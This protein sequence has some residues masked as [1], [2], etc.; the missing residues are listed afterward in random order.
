MKGKTVAITTSIGGSDQN[1]TMRFL[2]RD[3]MDP[4]RDIKYKSTDSGAAVLAMQNGEIAAALLSDQFIQKFL[5]DGTLRI[6]R[7]I[8]FDDDFK[9]ETCCI[10]AISKNIVENSPI[11]AKKLTQAHENA[12]QWI[13]GNR[14]EAVK[15]ML[16]NKWASGDFDKVLAFYNTLDYGV[17]DKNTEETLIKVI[18]DYKTCGILNKDFDTM[19]TLHRVWDGVLMEK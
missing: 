4:V 2:L 13:M 8:T 9:D 19:E 3:G 1:I 6:I 18:E 11:T 10:Y 7:S 12:R 15:L 5:P 14:E 16:E 17:T